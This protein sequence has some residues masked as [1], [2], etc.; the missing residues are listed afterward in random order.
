MWSPDFALKE[1]KQE[2]GDCEIQTLSIKRWRGEVLAR[3]REKNPSAPMTRIEFLA[4]KHAAH[5]Q[6]RSLME[7][8]V[9]SDGVQGEDSV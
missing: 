1:L 5:A 8:C 3:E 2:K 6:L 7:T 9:L 4:F